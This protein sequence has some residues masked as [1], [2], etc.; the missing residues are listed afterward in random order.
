MKHFQG[1]EIPENLAEI[2]DP[3]HSCLVVWDVQLALTGRVF[4]K[5]SYLQRLGP[6][7][8]ALRGRMPVAYTRITPLDLAFQGAWNIYGQMRRMGV[9]DPAQ[10]KPF[11][12]PGTPPHSI[13]PEVAPQPGDLVLD[14]TSP[15]L[16]L[17]TRFETLMRHRGVRT[18]L[19]TGISTEVGI[20]TSA[21][22]AG[23][24]GFFP[25]VVK[26]G[27]SSMDKDAHERSLLSLGRAALVADMAEI[28]TALG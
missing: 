24:R 14:K 1:M 10:L 11:L 20:E 3:K 25:V 27:V 18:L 13:A 15:N 7:V 23:A 16:F 9:D 5:D 21:R 26:D 4:D 28:T 2:V 19:F 17:G 8:S 6:F 22:D 12:V